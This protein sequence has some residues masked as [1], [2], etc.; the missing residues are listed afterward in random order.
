MSF[1]LRGPDC[2]S[3]TAKMDHS[4]TGTKQKQHSPCACYKSHYTAA[5]IYWSGL[6]PIA[7]MIIIWYYS[8]FS[9][10][11]SYQEE[12]ITIL[13]KQKV[14]KGTKGNHFP[15]N[16]LVQGCLTYHF[17]TYPTQIRGVAFTDVAASNCYFE[18][19]LSTNYEHIMECSLTFRLQW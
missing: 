16:P 1:I 19:D 8:R 4:A 17:N 6:Q 7:L 12:I 14:N 3:H 13:N 15:T 5:H 18:T 9:T 11:G 10:L 2:A